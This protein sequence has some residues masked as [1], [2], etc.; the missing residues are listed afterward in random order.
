MQDETSSI[1][2][3]DARPTPIFDES[4]RG[5]AR[6]GFGGEVDYWEHAYRGDDQ[7]DMDLIARLELVLGAAQ[8]LSPRDRPVLDIGCG[9]GVLAC[10]L[11]H[12]GYEK[13]FGVDI[14]P[15]MI[16]RAR[17]VFASEAP[18]EA[19]ARFEVADIDGLETLFPS[20]RFA[21]IT[22]VGLVEYLVDDWH[23]LTIARRLLEPGGH[24]VVT[25]PNADALTPLRFLRWGKNQWNRFAPNALRTQGKADYARR[26]YALDRFMGQA[27]EHGFEVV[28]W[29]GHGFK[30][31]PFLHRFGA[32]KFADS[33]FS[34]RMDL[35]ARRP[36]LKWAQ[37]A[38]ADIVVTLRRCDPEK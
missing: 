27:V 33:A 29:E 3:D 2:R 5:R 25:I 34:R 15:E 32:V 16:D 14:T 24:L 13:I 1:Q 6:D 26:V 28:G 4:Q 31:L 18:P 17:S 20:Q 10:R 30:M 36:G 7:G 9:A 12:L 35:I 11:A 23:S 21:L 22:C 38:A 19:N 8:R 37:R